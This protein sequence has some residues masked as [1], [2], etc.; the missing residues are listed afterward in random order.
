MNNVGVGLRA[1]AIIIDMLIL[2]VA[3]YVI[4]VFTGGTTASGFNLTGG[5][6]FLWFLVV[7]AYYIVMEVQQGGTIG[8]LMI[9][10]RVVKEDGGP[11]DWQASLIRNVLRIVDGLFFYLVGA[12][13]VWTSDRNQRLGDR[14]A[15]TVVVKKQSADA[16]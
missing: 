13:L 9:G 4:A 10:L 16:S 2:L 3:G 6:A 14:L 1:V 5:P 12:I 11:L 8:K 15:N 7:F